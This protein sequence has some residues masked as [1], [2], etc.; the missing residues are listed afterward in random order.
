[1]ADSAQ[2]IRL[3]ELQRD[4]L[5]PQIEAFLAAAPDTDAR[6][7]YATLR[8]AIVALEVPPDSADALGALIEVLLTA[9]RIRKL[10][11]PGAEQSL[12]SLFQKTPRGVE[13]AA[14]I[15]SINTA[16]N[17]LHGQTLEF[18]SVAARGPGAYGLTLRTPQ[19]Q[20][21]LRFEPSGV[22]VEAIELGRD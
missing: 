9:G 21:V 4:V 8:R 13:L 1:V 14:S 17:Q 20:M 2:S 15:S 11:G 10:Y 7:A 22:R 19:L 5:V 6:D 18:V 12:W 3:D 16:L